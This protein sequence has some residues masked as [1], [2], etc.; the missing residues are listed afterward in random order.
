MMKP[1]KSTD[2][3]KELLAIA[4]SLY[5]EERIRAYQLANRP[6][7]AR[8]Y[9]N[10][11]LIG[12]GLNFGRS[13][14]AYNPYTPECWQVLREKQRFDEKSISYDSLALKKGLANSYIEVY[15]DI[16]SKEGIKTIDDILEAHGLNEEE[17]T[18]FFVK[19]RERGKEQIRSVC[20]EVYGFC[21]GRLKE[22]SYSNLAERI[23]VSRKEVVTF[24]LDHFFRSGVDN[25]AF[26]DDLSLKLTSFLQREGL[27][28][29]EIVSRA[30]EAVEN[31]ELSYVS[32]W[33]E[34]ARTD[35]AKGQ[36]YLIDA[37][38]KIP[39]VK[40]PRDFVLRILNEYVRSGGE[41]QEGYD[42]R[43]A[44]IGFTDLY[45]DP[46]VRALREESI[47]HEIERGPICL[48]ERVEYAIKEFNL[49]PHE[50]WLNKALRQHMSKWTKDVREF[51]LSSAI[52]FGREY[53][54]LSGKK[55]KSLERKLGLVKKIKSQ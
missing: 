13:P 7:L 36:Y 1:S 26:T 6:D 46:S 28:G 25:L 49:N 52:Y 42:D 55:I 2:E 47:K 21:L 27:D 20:D 17:R 53:G 9:A 24:Y 10:E 45:N 43:T 34:L 16:L 37:L 35:K 40:F 39:T 41:L 29:E 51:D 48:G 12:E 11:L 50:G 19:I 54:L 3:Q 18:K 15:E 31:H 30:M 5:G 22:T 23:G 8:E 32:P 4:E 33:P 38:S 44:A 14:K